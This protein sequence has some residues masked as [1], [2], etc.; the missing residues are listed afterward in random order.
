MSRTAILLTGHMRTFDRCLPTQIHHVFRHYPE[1]D[2]FVSTIADAD[3]PKAQLLVDRYGSGRVHIDIIPQQP[4]LDLPPGCPPEESYVPGQLFMHEPYAISVSPQAIL[5][6]LWQLHRT[7]E[8]FES[9]AR[10]SDYTT[11]IR[12][13]PDSYFHSFEPVDL[14]GSSQAYTPW[15]GRFGGVNDRCAIMGRDAARAYFTTFDR[16]SQLIAEGCPL[17]PESLIATALKSTCEIH[18]DTLRAEFTTLKMVEGQLQ[19]RPP[20]ISPID[21]AHSR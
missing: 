17:H 1:A 13:R 15:W 3:A 14:F 10:T 2:F 12:V 16:L 21:L 4:T 11:V 20:E 5:R 7:W 8:F 9:R 6:Q 19:A 18:G